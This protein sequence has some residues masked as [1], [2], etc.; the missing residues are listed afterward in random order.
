MSHPAARALAGALRLHLRSWPDRVHGAAISGAWGHLARG[1]P[2]V[3]RLSELEGQ[4]IAVE[5]TDTGNVWTFR[6]APPRLEALPPGSP[7]DIRVRGEAEDLL[8]LALHLE[9]ADTLFFNRRLDMEGDTATGVRLKNFLDALEVDWEVHGETVA[10]LLPT[11]LQGPA[12]RLLG[13]MDPGRRLASLRAWLA[14]HWLGDGDP[15]WG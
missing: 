9:D 12:R 4:R 2:F 3:R 10:D 7:W 15:A 14:A 8:R 11:P 6:V 5:V 13:E 1:Q